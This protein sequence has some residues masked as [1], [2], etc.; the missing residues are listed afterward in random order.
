MTQTL[1]YKASM[2]NSHGLIGRLHWVKK[3]HQTENGCGLSG[4][5][6]RI[7]SGIRTEY[8]DALY[9]AV[10]TNKPT[11]ALEIGMAFGVSTLAILTAPDR[12]QGNGKLISLD[13]AQ[14]SYWKGCGLSV[15]FPVK[16]TL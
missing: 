4:E 2:E 14:S 10:L 9:R 1:N 5:L 12:I 13:P 8:A 11:L 7:H 3:M 15:S 6:V 16:Q